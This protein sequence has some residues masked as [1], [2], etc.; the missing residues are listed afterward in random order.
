MWLL[1]ATFSKFL[2]S[3]LPDYVFLAPCSLP[4]FSLCSLLPWVSRAILPAPWLPLTGV[5]NCFLIG[6]H[7][8][9]KAQRHTFLYRNWVRRHR[10]S[11][12]TTGFQYVHVDVQILTLSGE[13]QEAH[14][15][16]T[17]NLCV[18]VDY[19]RN[20]LKSCGAELKICESNWILVWKSGSVW[21]PKMQFCCCLNIF[22]ALFTC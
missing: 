12:G 13:A 17:E 7:C 11:V 6:V 2:C 10:I 22:F 14:S 4:Y 16:E 9:W 3:L 19:C 21:F 20:K 1:P 18:A 5:H 15:S 8:L